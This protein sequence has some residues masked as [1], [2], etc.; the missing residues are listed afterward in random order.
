M[1]RILEG[2]KKCMSREADCRKTGYEEH[3]NCIAGEEFCQKLESFARPFSTKSHH[4]CHLLK[5]NPVQ[6]EQKIRGNWSVKPWG[7]KCPDGHVFCPTAMRCVREDDL[8]N[9]TADEQFCKV[10]FARAPWKMNHSREAGDKFCCLFMRYRD[11]FSA[12]G[13]YLFWVA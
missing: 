13:A 5:T 2:L 12:Q 6:F 11:R 9:C 1:A 3:K 4:L 8:S 10:G 7:G